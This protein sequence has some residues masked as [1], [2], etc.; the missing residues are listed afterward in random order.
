MTD[1]DNYI[2]EHQKRYKRVP[3]VGFNFYAIQ[4]QAKLICNCKGRKFFSCD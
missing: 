3:T 2:D 4:Y 1:T